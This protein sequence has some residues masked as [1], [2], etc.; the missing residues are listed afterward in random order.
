MKVLP[1]DRPLLAESGHAYKFVQAAAL[2]APFR[3]PSGRP[4]CAEMNT[5]ILTLNACSLRNGWSQAG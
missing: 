5:I 4:G 1:G 2:E 3:P